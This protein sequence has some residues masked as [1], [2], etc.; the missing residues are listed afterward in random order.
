MDQSDE[1]S[2]PNMTSSSRQYC[3][4]DHFP[5]GHVTSTWGTLCLPNHMRCDGHVTCNSGADELMCDVNCPNLTFPCMNGTVIGSM[6]RC[7]PYAKRCD[8][9]IDCSDGSDE[10]FCD[11]INALGI[12]N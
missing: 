10:T 2:C 5:C 8:N 9:V 6:E 12:R 4:A 3:P 1:T 11:N 7:V